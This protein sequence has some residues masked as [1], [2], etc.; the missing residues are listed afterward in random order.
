MELADVDGLGSEVGVDSG[1]FKLSSLRIEISKLFI[2]ENLQV[3][4]S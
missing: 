4:N 2:V 3:Q 1:F